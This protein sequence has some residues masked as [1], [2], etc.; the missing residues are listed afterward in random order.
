M[1][2]TS[3]YTKACFNAWMN[4]ED[5]LANMAQLQTSLSKKAVKLV[6]ECAMICM[7]T[8]HALKSK[9]VNTSKYAMLCIGVCEECAELCDELKG[10]N[11]KQCALACRQCSETI[12][13][14]AL[15]NL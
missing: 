3:S 8:F 12:T 5:L 10:E 13:S 14:L 9:S 7:S 11:F 4:C 2:V 15:T 1:L 6:D